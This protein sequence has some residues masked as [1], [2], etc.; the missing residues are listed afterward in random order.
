MVVEAEK[1]IIEEAQATPDKKKSKARARTVLN[2]MNRVLVVIEGTSVFFPPAKLAVEVLKG[3]LKLELDRRDNSEQIVA[4]F[5]SMT[6]MLFVL[7]HLDGLALGEDEL[8]WRLEHLLD[9]MRKSMEEFGDLADLYYNKCKQP[10][11]RFFKSSDFKLRMQLFNDQFN[12]YRRDLQDVLLVRADGRGQT[13]QADVER[14]KANT[15]LILARLGQPVNEQE[16]QAVRLVEACGREVV[17]HDKAKLEEVSVLIGGGRVTGNTQALLDTSLDDLLV[18]NMKQFHFK[19]E[20]SMAQMHE[21]VNKAKEA[22]LKKLDSGPH[23]LIEDPDVKAVWQANAW[24]L[25]VKCRHFVDELSNHYEEK[26]RNEIIKND[27]QTPKDNWTLA[28]IS[29]VM[30][31]PAIGDAIDEDGSGFISLYEVNSFLTQRPESWSTPEWLAYWAIGW[32]MSNIK[33]TNQI[34]EH[35]D[36][37]SKLCRQVVDKHKGNGDEGY[38]GLVTKYTQKLRIMRNMNSWAHTVQADDSAMQDLSME[39]ETRL[40]EL[41]DQASKDQIKIIS[42]RLD[43]LKWLLDDPADLPV[44]LGGTDTR[45]ELVFL[46]IASLILGR[47]VEDMEQALSGG[48]VSDGALAIMTETLDMLTDMFHDRMQALIRGWRAQKLHVEL[49]ITC[50]AGGIYAGWY[51]A[52]NHPSGEMKRLVDKASTADES[53]ELENHSNAAIMNEVKSLNASIVQVND[54]IGRLDERMDSIVSMLQTLIAAAQKSGHPAPAKKVATTEV[55]LGL[56]S[57]PQIE[58]PLDLQSESLGSALGSIISPFSTVTDVA[59]SE[60]AAPVAAITDALSGGLLTGA[61]EYR[62]TIGGMASSLRVGVS[63]FKRGIK[64]STKPGKGDSRDKNIPVEVKV[65]IKSDDLDDIVQGYG[66]DHEPPTK[67]PETQ[68]TNAVSFPRL[69][70]MREGSNFQSSNGSHDDPGPKSPEAQVDRGGIVIASGHELS[71]EFYPRDIYSPD[72]QNALSEGGS[73]TWMTDGRSAGTPVD[74][75]KSPSVQ[76]FGTPGYEDYSVPSPRIPM[77]ELG[78][79]TANTLRKMRKQSRSNLRDGHFGSGHDTRPSTDESVKSSGSAFGG[80]GKSMRKRLNSLKGSKETPSKEWERPPAT[81]D[82]YP[83][84]S[85][86]QITTSKEWEGASPKLGHPPSS[87][88]RDNPPGHVRPAPPQQYN[89][90][91]PVDYRDVP[92]HTRGEDGYRSDPHTPNSAP[93]LNGRRPIQQNMNGYERGYPPPNMEQQWNPGQQW[94]EPPHWSPPNEGRVDRGAESDGGASSLPWPNDP[95]SARPFRHQT[96]HPGVSSPRPQGPRTRGLSSPAN[97]PH[98]HLI[99]DPRG[100]GNVF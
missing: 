21:S 78:N 58:I 22:I 19:L 94:R 15:E 93:P 43:V 28:I 97:Q 8:S 50:F 10:V 63:G 73:T 37:L 57:D 39:G 60:G 59:V 29:K 55:K 53:D 99:G 4:M 51:N 6:T 75:S 20:A 62:E 89:S 48:S 3:L 67:H 23:E 31:H 1:W 18:S 69:P 52:Y 80:F 96:G 7:R 25:S 72:S 91:S 74:L 2:T 26:F 90:A 16:A 41:L 83:L 84:S 46:C 33:Y 64:G 98:Q 5:H 77:S 88:S 56:E 82:H 100:R 49:H 61:L 14:I 34:A 35:L 36:D 92:F 42:E 38:A 11:V 71:K 32:R 81:P 40:Q 9:A 85:R 44:L 45:I 27:G 87:S 30:H 12:Q 17:L 54:K 24:R 76:T 47:H 86:G 68:G 65:P 70:D 13:M 95:P 66:Y 79:A